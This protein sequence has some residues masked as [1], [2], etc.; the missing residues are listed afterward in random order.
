[1]TDFGKQQ[2]QCGHY[3]GL[4]T[5]IWGTWARQCSHSCAGAAAWVPALANLQLTSAQVPFDGMS[6]ILSA[7]SSAA[8]SLHWAPVH[9]VKILA[10]LNCLSVLLQTW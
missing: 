2:L 4:C 6:Y 10:A 9:Y 5:K 1:M 3:M 7:C 8:L